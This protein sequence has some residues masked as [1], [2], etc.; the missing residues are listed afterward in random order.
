[1]EPEE[2][3]KAAT[4]GTEELRAALASH[5]IKLPLL[6]PDPIT[7]TAGFPCPLISLGSCNIETASKLTAVL[8]A[9]QAPA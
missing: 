4:K 2:L 8:R 5:G 3:S 6:R 9:S 1:M 7:N